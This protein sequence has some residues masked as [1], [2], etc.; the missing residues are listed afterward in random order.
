MGNLKDL[1]SMIPGMGK[2]LKDVEISNDA[3][4]GIEAIINS[5]TPHE[6]E[7]PEVIR[8]SRVQRIAKGSGMSVQEVNRVLKQFEQ[9]RKMMHMATTM[10]NPAAMMRQMR[11]RRK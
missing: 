7:N 4:K 1:A 11:G 10:K 6:R 3:F 9:T 5:M 2:A 8:G